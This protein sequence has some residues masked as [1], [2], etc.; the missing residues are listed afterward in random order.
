[1]NESEKS[2]FESFLEKYSEKTKKLSGPAKWTTLAI[3][4][5]LTIMGVLGSF[6]FMNFNMN[7]YAIFLEKFAILY[8]PLVASVGTGKIAGKIVEKK[9]ENGPIKAK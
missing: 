4:F 5:L 6:N 3:I 2:L 8:V 1:M 9:K 7:D